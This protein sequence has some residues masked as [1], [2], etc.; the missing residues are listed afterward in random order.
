L[1]VSDFFRGLLEYYKIKHVLMN[2]YGIFNISIFL[3]FDEDFLSIKPHWALC[4]KLFRVKL[5]PSTNG[6]PS[7][8]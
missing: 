7:T 2:P 5:Q 6:W 1:H 3:H 4:R 8:L